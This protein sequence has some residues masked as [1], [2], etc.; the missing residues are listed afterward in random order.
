MAEIQRTQTYRTA[1]GC[2]FEG[3]LRVWPVM[4]IQIKKSDPEAYTAEGHWS[5]GGGLK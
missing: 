2:C 5:P 1:V 3:L 4:E